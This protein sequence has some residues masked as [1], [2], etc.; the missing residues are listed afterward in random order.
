MHQQTTRDLREQTRDVIHVLA[1]IPA[2]RTAEIERIFSHTHWQ[3]HLAHSI[4]EAVQALRSLNVSVVLCEQHLPDGTWRN[5]VHETNS[6]SSGPLTI[7]LSATADSDLWRDIL[8]CGA[9][10]LLPRPLEPRELFTVVPMA[11]R[12]W[13][14]VESNFIVKMPLDRCNDTLGTLRF[15]A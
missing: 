2:E 4:Q 8:D 14:S 9:Y 10:D 13:R 1:V 15:R 3:L 12:Q 11:W 5:V 6:L 7:V